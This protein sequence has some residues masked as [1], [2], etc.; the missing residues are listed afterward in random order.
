MNEYSV[1]P[2]FIALAGLG[3]STVCDNLWALRDFLPVFRNRERL[4]G[5]AKEIGGENVDEMLVALPAA[6]ATNFSNTADISVQ[7]FSQGTVSPFGDW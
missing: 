6:R 1:G 7:Y 2:K 4:N 3:I 5:L